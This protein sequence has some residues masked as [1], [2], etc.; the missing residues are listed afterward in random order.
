MNPNR[1]IRNET[2]A[3]VGA[4]HEVTLAAFATLTISH[5]TEQF[6][7]ERHNMNRHASTY[8][9]AI[10]SASWVAIWAL[11]FGSPSST[12]AQPAFS[13]NAV[14]IIKLVVPQNGYALLANQ[15]NTQ[16]NKLATALPTFVQDGLFIKW[17]T[18]SQNYKTYIYDTDGGWFDLDTWTPANPAWVPGEGA[19]L[20]N[21]DTTHPFTVTLAGDVPQGTNL[22]VAL[23]QGYSLVSSILPLA[24][25]A[26]AAGVPG[27]QDEVFTK[28]SANTQSYR[29][30]V[31]DDSAGWQSFDDLVSAIPLCVVGG[32]FFIFNPTPTA[33]NWT[34]SFQITDPT[35][36]V[37]NL[38]LTLVSDA[39]PVAVAFPSSTT[40]LYTLL[41][42]T[43]LTVSPPS[44]M[45]V[46][47]SGQTDIPG[48]DRM[49]ILTDPD[50]FDQVFYQVS[51]RS[52]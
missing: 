22:A 16:D 6:I 33:L 7:T 30:F 18:T 25:D 11:A 52:L 42:A 34:R 10:L 2:A 23:P 15:L 12:T 14:G 5:H 43:D 48:T 49:L 41:R 17:D 44:S 37:A 28:W 19:F 51:E 20:F 13:V 8:H 3:D 29:S 9:Q 45:W 21:P 46:P 36:T 38:R 27:V 4:I 24:Q 32:S 31:Y 1:V 35:N 39:T 47:V 26:P 40:R 50:Q